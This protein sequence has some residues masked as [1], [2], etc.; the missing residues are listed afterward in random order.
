MAEQR[1]QRRLAAILAADVVGYS[2]LMERDESGTLA[3]LKALRREI[4]DP[5]IARH[6][7]RIVKLMGDGALVEFAS[8]VDAVT[9]AVEIQK[10]LREHDPGGPEELRIRLRIGINVGD[11][12]VD[13]DDI[14]GDGVNLAARIEALAEP[15]GVFISRSVADQ[16][17]DKLPLR[18]ESRGEHMVKNIA[19]PIEVFVVAEAGGGI[20]ATSSAVVARPQAAQAGA[21]PAIAV[22]AFNNMSG[23]AEQEYF[24]DGISEDIITDLSKLSDLHVIARNSAFVYKRSAVAIPE[25]AKALGVRYVLEGSVRRAG[26]RIRVTAQLIDATTGGHAWAERYD[27]DLTDIFAVQDELTREIVAALKVSLTV[28][29]SHRRTQK[30]D[31][32]FEA[33]DLFLRGREHVWLETRAGN[34]SARELLGRVIAI[35]PDYAPAHAHIA[36]THVIDYINGWGESPDRSLQ[37]GLEIARRALAI[38]DEEAV[39]HFVVA[40]VQLWRRDFDQAYV[41]IA[42]CVALMPSWIRGRLLMARIQIF[43]GRPAE[44]VETLDL[45]MRLDPHHPD[46]MLQFVADARFL[47]GEYEPAVAALAKRLARNPDATSAHALIAA[48]YGH[49]GRIAEG[50]AAWEQVLRLEPGYSIERQRRILPFRNPADFERR[51]DGLRRLGLAV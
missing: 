36:V 46:I 6:A 41:A 38:D 3:R 26:N 25:I 23:D 49:L 15:G 11:V 9:S 34:I 8:A 7:G 30:R 42:R 33:H 1:V 28:E 21:K 14:Y 39:A 29:E 17:R 37:L 16:V 19:R 45:I 24:A 44:A 35:V 18:I 4:I 51:V 27:R 50:R 47:L 10:S 40:A 48:A 13:G 2:R 31:I 43:D 5:G 20:A 12:I 22:L 32:E